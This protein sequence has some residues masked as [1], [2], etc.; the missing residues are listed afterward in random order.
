MAANEFFLL[1]FCNAIALMRAL[2]K[3]PTKVVIENSTGSLTEFSL[4]MVGD[5]PSLQGLRCHLICHKVT[6]TSMKPRISR[7]KSNGDDDHI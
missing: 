6:N 1:N 5:K 3:E 7:H 4:C 2:L